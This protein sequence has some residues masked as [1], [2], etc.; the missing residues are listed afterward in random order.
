MN[1]DPSRIMPVSLPP[2]RRWPWIVAVVIG[3]V[4][5]AGV[6][7][8]PQIACRLVQRQCPIKSDGVVIRGVRC[9]G[10]PATTAMVV[11]QCSPSVF[12][13][14]V[15]GASGRWLPGLV[16][17]E[18]QH[19]WGTFTDAPE[20]T[21]R[22]DLDATADEPRISAQIPQAVAERLLAAQL[23]QARSPLSQVKFA[24]VSLT[25]EPHAADTHWQV[26]LRGSASIQ[27]WNQ[28]SEIEVEKLTVS[29]TTTFTPRPDGDHGLTAHLVIKDMRGASPFGPLAPFAPLIQKQVNQDLG[30]EMPKVLVPG[31]WPTATHWDLKIVPGG[32]EF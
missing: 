32:V 30:R 12:K 13:Q 21:W 17:S 3:V 23:R 28:P 16:L 6:L 2:R 22:L 11:G 31:W 25:G 9:G 18:G 1:L 19:A 26:S 7:L 5:V 10:N 29:V 8:A 4:V 14:I 24:D 27:L 15:E 20:V